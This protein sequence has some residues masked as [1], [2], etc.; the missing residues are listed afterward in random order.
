MFQ[1][2]ERKPLSPGRRKVLHGQVRE[3]L[4]KSFALAMPHSQT[5]GPHCHSVPATAIVMNSLDPV[6]SAEIVT[7]RLPRD[8]SLP[9]GQHWHGSSSRRHHLVR[10]LDQRLHMLDARASLHGLNHSAISKHH[11][12]GAGA[13]GSRCRGLFQWPA[14]SISLSKSHGIQ[15]AVA[16]RIECGPAAPA[17]YA[18][19]QRSLSAPKCTP[20]AKDADHTVIPVAALAGCKVRGERVNDFGGGVQR[21]RGRMS[22]DV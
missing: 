11:F 7:R 1:G 3:R 15:P 9:A 21:A 13:P 6:R 19:A 20:G 8:W 22:S 17:M 10:L 18:V 2:E 12:R 5:S 14:T 16:R 4:A